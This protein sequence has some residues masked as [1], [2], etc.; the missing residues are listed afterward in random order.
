VTSVFDNC[1]GVSVSDVKIDH[2]TSDETENGNGDGNTLNDIVIASDCRSV[3]LRSERNG[4]GDGRVYTITFRLTD[5]HNNTTTVTARVVVVH[6]PG[7]TPV[8][9]GVQYTVNGGCP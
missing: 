4:G 6:N 7:E 8:D 2:V 1:G 3:Q 5:T 9:S